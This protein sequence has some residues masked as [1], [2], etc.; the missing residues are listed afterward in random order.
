MHSYLVSQCDICLV[1]T[2]WSQC[3]SLGLFMPQPFH[4]YVFF[5]LHLLSMPWSN[6][7]RKVKKGQIFWGVEQ[8]KMSFHLS[9]AQ[10]LELQRFPLYR[11][12]CR[13]RHGCTLIWSYNISPALEKGSVQITKRTAQKV[14]GPDGVF[15]MLLRVS[16][17]VF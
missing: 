3:L 10:T 14:F 1:L 9:W 13:Y 8:L 17:G 4:Y 2:P 12:R 5:T 6:F 15:Q 11:H 7:F 16:T